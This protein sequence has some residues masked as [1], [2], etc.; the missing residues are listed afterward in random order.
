MAT[1]FRPPLITR[2]ERTIPSRSLLDLDRGSL[3]LTTLKSQ[4]QFFGVA[5]NP[6]YDWPNP[7]LRKPPPV[8]N[9]TWRD[10]L[11]LNLLGKDQFFGAPG[12]PLVYDWQ[13]PRGYAF[14]TENRTYID[15]S[16]FW[17][18]KDAF[19]GL[20]GN[21]NF[22]WPNPRSATPA[23]QLRTWEGNLL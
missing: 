1:I 14:P 23:I 21:P 4:D 16:E 2:I 13:N 17:M 22:D 18:L 12:Q 5:G 6:N 11:K 3:L 20:A 7:T 10:P 15:A 9:Y 19:F 8:D